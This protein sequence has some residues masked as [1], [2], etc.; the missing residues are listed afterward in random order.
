MPTELTV[1]PAEPADAEDLALILNG[2]SEYKRGRGD[3]AWP[4]LL[5]GEDA[6]D[7]IA[8]GDTH[9]AWLADVRVATLALLWSDDMMWGAQPPVAAYVHQLAIRDGY[10]G[11]GIGAEVL[12]WAGGRAAEAHRPLLRIDFPPANDGL[13][14]YYRRIGFEWV[15]DTAIRGKRRTYTATLWQRPSSYRSATAWNC[16]TTPAP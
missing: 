10:H 7:R 5:S 1:L 13:R 9:V 14:R 15:R 2:A 8:V 4:A 11:L 12:N 16:P 3:D 6:Q